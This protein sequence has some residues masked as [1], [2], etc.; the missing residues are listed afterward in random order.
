MKKVRSISTFDFGTL[1]VTIPHKPLLTVLSEA[2][3]FVSESKVT[4][5]IGFSKTSIY[6]TSNGAGRRYFTK[7]ILANNK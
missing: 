7:Q 6:W 4:K 2:I 5:H 1:Y 3:S